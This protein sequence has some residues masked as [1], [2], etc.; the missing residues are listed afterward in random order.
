MSQNVAWRKRWWWKLRVGRRWR[1]AL[2][3]HAPPG[4]PHVGQGHLLRL[5]SAYESGAKRNVMSMIRVLEEEERPFYSVAS[6]A[7]KLAI[8]ERNLRR[9]CLIVGS[10]RG[11]GLG[12]S[13][14]LIRLMCVLG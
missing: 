11:T 14:G 10:C 1:W 5:A 6:L 8:S 3:L 4:D 9:T 12:F 2:H 13:A 7:K